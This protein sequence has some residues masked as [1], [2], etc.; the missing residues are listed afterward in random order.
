M[1]F[2]GGVKWK[3][4]LTMWYKVV[5]SGKITLYLNLIEPKTYAAFYRFI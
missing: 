5:K 4:L 3:N 2:L 1:V